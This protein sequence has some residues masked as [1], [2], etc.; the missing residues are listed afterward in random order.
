MAIAPRRMDGNS[1][2]TVRPI[3]TTGSAE[4]QINNL[5]PY[6]RHSAPDHTTKSCTRALVEH[7]GHL[8]E[9]AWRYVET[10]AMIDSSNQ[11]S[12]EFLFGIIVCHGEVLLLSLGRHFAS[13]SDTEVANAVCLILKDF[14]VNTSLFH[15]RMP[16]HPYSRFL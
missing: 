6:S 12:G 5:C 9:E 14:R 10:P 8:E 7:L 3:G 4:M 1:N 2:H 15:K 11:D 16:R 13:S